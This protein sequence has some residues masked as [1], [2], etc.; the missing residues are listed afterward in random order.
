MR[1]LSAPGVPSLTPPPLVQD[2]GGGGV[3]VVDV[4]RLSKQRERAFLETVL[5]HGDADNIKLLQ[6]MRQR[7]DRWASQLRTMPCRADPSF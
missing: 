4:A 5:E 3:E 2:G 1:A 7:L 6:K